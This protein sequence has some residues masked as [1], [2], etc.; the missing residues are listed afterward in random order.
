MHFGIAFQFGGCE[1]S[2]EISEM[3]DVFDAVGLENGRFEIRA[4][5]RGADAHG[6]EE[7]SSDLDFVHDSAHFRHHQRV[8]L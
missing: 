8:I 6:D 3:D 2:I 1:S 7:R 4:G 5:I